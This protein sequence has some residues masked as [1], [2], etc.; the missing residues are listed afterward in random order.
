MKLVD[1]IPKCANVSP[2][3][4]LVSFIFLYLGTKYTRPLLQKWTLLRGEP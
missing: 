1:T 3:L 4:M 2:S